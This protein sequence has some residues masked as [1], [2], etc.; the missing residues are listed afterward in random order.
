MYILSWNDW[1]RLYSFHLKRPD[2]QWQHETENYLVFL[3][4]F[5]DADTSCPLYHHSSGLEKC[6]ENC[7]NVF[8]VANR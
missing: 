6:Q 7:L 3:P 5:V 1:I 2:V 4:Y 8:G